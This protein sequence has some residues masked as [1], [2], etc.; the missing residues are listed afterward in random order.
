MKYRLNVHGT[1]AVLGELVGDT[2]FR[3]LLRISLVLLKGHRSLK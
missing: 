2:N 1:F 3:E